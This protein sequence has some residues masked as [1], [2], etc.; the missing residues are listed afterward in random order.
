MCARRNFDQMLA[1]A[2]D[3]SPSRQGADWSGDRQ[4]S[5]EG[6]TNLAFHYMYE[7]LHAS[8]AYVKAGQ[9]SWKQ[10]LKTYT[11]K[12]VGSVWAVSDPKPGLIV[13]M[14]NLLNKMKRDSQK[15]KTKSSI[16]LVSG[17]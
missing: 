13:F 1:S 11:E 9:L 6:T 3:A 8:R 4:D 2:S 12:R 17:D 16:L 14:G 10:I 15:I 7:D 5:L